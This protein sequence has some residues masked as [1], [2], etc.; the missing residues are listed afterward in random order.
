MTD[1][2]SKNPPVQKAVE[3][4]GPDGDR[5]SKETN[6]EKAA[7][8]GNTRM[9]SGSYTMRISHNTKSN[10][11]P[12]MLSSSETPSDENP[13]HLT[14][15][16][17][18]QIRHFRN[19]NP[20]SSFKANLSAQREDYSVNSESSSSQEHGTGFSR[21]QIKS[22]T[23]RE[24][25]IIERKDHKTELDSADK[26]NGRNYFHQTLQAKAE[27]QESYSST[28]LSSGGNNYPVTF[29]DDGLQNGRQP[30]L[31]GAPAPLLTNSYP[32]QSEAHQT[33]LKTFAPVA[34]A[35]P[36]SGP[37]D[38]SKQT[39]ASSGM[40]GQEGGVGADSSQASDHESISLVMP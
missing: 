22:R 35:R 9:S 7:V 37:G 23:I 24:K 34:E 18:H 21:P 29:D 26:K 27:R 17:K 32:E 31:P 16:S 28:E 19:D 13:T 40:T 5:A 1:G 4:K 36:D 3:N 6:T 8:A 39:G 38:D 11:N 12:D 15:F 10:Y 2:T 33:S 20:T 25:V 14:A 30:E